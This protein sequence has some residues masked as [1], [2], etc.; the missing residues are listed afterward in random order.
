MMRTEYRHLK[1]GTLGASFFWLR[2]P[3]GATWV[4]VGCITEAPPPREVPFQ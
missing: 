4:L 2:L 3:V 1:D